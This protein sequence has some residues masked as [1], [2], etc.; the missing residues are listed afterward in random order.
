MDTWIWAKQIGQ[1]N[2]VGTIHITGIAIL[3]KFE[4]STLLSTVLGPFIA[5]FKYS[6]CIIDL[7]Y[8]TLIFARDTTFFMKY[9]LF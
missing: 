3:I 7:I 2:R 5:F 8:C 9:F 6:Y 4:F 1:L